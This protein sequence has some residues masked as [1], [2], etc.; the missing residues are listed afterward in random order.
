MVSDIYCVCENTSL[1]INSLTYFLS[2]LFQRTSDSFL[3]VYVF[4]IQDKDGS[5]NGWGYYDM[6]EFFGNYSNTIEIIFLNAC[7]TSNHAKYISQKGFYAIGVN[8]EIHDHVALKFS[9]VFYE[10]LLNLRT[11]KGYVEA[12]RKAVSIVRQ[13][14]FLC[15]EESVPEL[16]Y[17]GEKIDFTPTQEF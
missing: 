10:Y 7:W 16:W 1:I 15:K 4:K 3:K 6:A 8:A 11:K 9:E 5:S 17:N 12:Y 14:P 2:P 13:P